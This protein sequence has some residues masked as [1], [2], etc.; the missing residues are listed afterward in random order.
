MKKRWFLL[1]M[2]MILVLVMCGVSDD[3]GA[4][5]VYSEPTGADVYLDDSLTG[6]RTDCVLE[7][8]TS[9]HHTVFVSLEGYYGW[10]EGVVVEPGEVDTVDAVLSPISSPLELCEE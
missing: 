3:T 1:G 5:A 6:A 4:I 10:E 7:D 9:G 8:V 2:G